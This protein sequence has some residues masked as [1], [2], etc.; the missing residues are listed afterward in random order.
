[1]LKTRNRYVHRRTVVAFGSQIAFGRGG[2]DGSIGGARDPDPDLEAAGEAGGLKAGSGDVDYDPDLADVGEAGTLEHQLLGSIDPV[3]DVA[4]S[5]A[6]AVEGEGADH[7]IADSFSEEADL[8]AAFNSDGDDSD[9]EIDGSS[10]DLDVD[11][12]DA[13]G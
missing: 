4:A 12:G 3:A 11:A 7:F 13:L 6:T 8:S 9:I 1:M 5:P 10:F 2:L